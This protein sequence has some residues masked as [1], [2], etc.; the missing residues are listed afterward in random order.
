MA[1]KY[2]SAEYQQKVQKFVQREVVYCV[3]YLI[4]ELAKDEKYT[5]DLLPIIQ[6]SDWE[7]AAQEH[8]AKLHFREDDGNWCVLD[9]KDNGMWDMLFGSKSEAAQEYCEQN[10]IEPQTKEAYEHWIVSDW[11]MRELDAK[12]E[13]VTD[14]M[15]MNLWGRACS[16]QAIALDQVIRDIYDE[17]HGEETKNK[18]QAAT[19]D[20]LISIK[21]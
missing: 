8:G 4:S 2:E 12:G 3:S 6:Q 10:D 16:G 19:L 15:N 11:L 9:Q 21:P 20:A 17:L 13:M 7:S 5:D 14:F 18:Q 1:T